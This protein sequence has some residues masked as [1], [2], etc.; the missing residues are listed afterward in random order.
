MEES[1]ISINTKIAAA[2]GMVIVSAMGAPRGLSA[3]AAVSA[4]EVRGGTAT[5]EASTNIPAITVH[6]RSTA[7]DARANVRDGSAGLTVESAVATLPVKSLATG[8]GLRDQHM[9]K[10]VFTSPDGRV[11]DVRFVSRQATCKS[12][13]ARRQAACTVSGDLAIR[14][15]LRPFTM[16]LTV[17]R[18]GAAFRAAG[19]GVVKLSAYG[20]EQPSQ[21]GVRTRDEVK[22]H[23]DFTARPVTNTMARLGV[24]R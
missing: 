1:M 22:L 21:F 16:K 7:L 11:H 20:I 4:V 3:A 8:M 24:V 5:F 12:D 13:A 2:C 15:I 6:G 9:R 17:I 14:G 23:L 18:D 10:L 19:D